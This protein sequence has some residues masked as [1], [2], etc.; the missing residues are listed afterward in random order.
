MKPNDN[1]SDRDKQIYTEREREEE[2]DLHITL[3]KVKRSDGHVSEATAEDS[4][5]STGS[6]EGGR[7]ELDLA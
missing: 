2:R 6:I 7:V 3:D 1:K 4:T 5:S